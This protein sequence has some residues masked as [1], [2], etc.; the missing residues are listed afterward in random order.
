MK[1]YRPEAKEQFLKNLHALQVAF[2]LRT[3]ELAKRIGVTRQTIVNIK[4]KPEKAS[5]AYYYALVLAFYGALEEYPDEER[6]WIFERAF[7]E[8]LVVMV[9]NNSRQFSITEAKVP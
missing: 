8:E 4:A 2:N 3:E 5:I 1:L 6:K 9:R 7:D